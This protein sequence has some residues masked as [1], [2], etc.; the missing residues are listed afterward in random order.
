MTP[1]TFL[2]PFP[3]VLLSDPA[4]DATQGEYAKYIRGRDV[5]HLAY[6]P[7]EQPTV[8]H[9]R[10]LS[11]AERREVGNK[12]TEFDKY[13]A[14]FVRGLVRVERLPHE[15]ERR[16][17]FR[18][19][20]H[21]GNAK[22][23]PDSVLDQYFD[24]VMIQEV[25]MCIYMRSFLA[26]SRGAFFPV[27]ATSQLALA[28]LALHHAAQTPVTSTSVANSSP[29]KAV[30]ETAPVSSQDGVESIDA[31]ATVTHT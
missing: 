15:G 31:T 10:L 19:D 1:Q 6:F 4:I 11:V 13:Q 18:P 2:K 20:D 16:D 21:S 8:F 3:V 22:L 25:G 28:A 30:S 26:K 5:S 7:G 9:C 12:A 17:W 23:I 14:A 24:E 27:P 29:P